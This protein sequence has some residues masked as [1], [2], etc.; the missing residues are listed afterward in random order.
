MDDTLVPFVDGVRNIIT[1]MVKEDYLTVHRN[2]PKQVTLDQKWQALFNNIN[3]FLLICNFTTVEYEYVSGSIKNHLGYDVSDYSTEELTN[4][5]GSIIHE[6][7]VSFMLNT[8]LP[9][10]YKYLGEHSSRETPGLNYR[11][12]CCSRL[13]N[14]AGTYAWYLIDSAVI[15]VDENGSPVKTLITCTNIDQFKK[16]ECIYYNILRKNGEGVYEV[17]FEGS[18]HN[19]RAVSNLTPREIEIINLISRGSSNKQ[20][21]DKLSIALHTVQTHRKRILKKTQCK[22]T[23]EL[24]NFAFSRG[25]L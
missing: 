24:T 16:D 11:F 5:I 1:G 13:K 12:T 15:H 10:V 17:V 18:E 22:G 3:G 7:D 9:V 14:A 25:L 20:I 4:F 2:L 21:A 19:D 8:F 23:A 6:R